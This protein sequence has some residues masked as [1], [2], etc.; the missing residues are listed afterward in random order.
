MA[1]LL[2]SQI[3]MEIAMASVLESDSAQL[4]MERMLEFLTAKLWDL[5]IEMALEKVSTLAILLVSLLME[6][7]LGTL[8]V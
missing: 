5:Q 6:T 3:E 7:M 4:S 1:Q 2:D 8:T